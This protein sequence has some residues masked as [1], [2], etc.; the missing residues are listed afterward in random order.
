MKL[1]ALAYLPPKAFGCSKVFAEN[2]D[3]FP[4]KYDLLTY[5]ESEDWP[6]A[7]RLKGNPE[8]VKNT[9]F[10]DGRPNPFAINNL[11]FFTGVRIAQSKGYTHFI[12]LESDC[13]V[14]R[15][16]W[17]EVIFEEYFNL[18]K[19][20]LA[21]GTL[22]CY[23]PNNF[24]LL[25]AKRW[26]ELVSKN[27]SRNVPIA[28][29]GWKGAAEK[30]PCCVFPNGA[31]GVYDLAWMGQLFDLNNTMDVAKCHTA[32]DMAF[33]VN[34]WKLFEEDSYEVLGMLQSVFSS[35]GDVLTTEEQRLQWLR[36]GKFVAV[37]Q[38]K[39]QASV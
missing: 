8:Q 38:V 9:T 1:C 6:G 20:T 18:G 32:W 26:A 11:V 29:Y 14:G 36:E 19:P 34:I 12:Y 31:L 7:V 13:R 10:Q 21:A 33:G 23:N 2:L 37:H 30:F 4:T 5:S 15:K 17:D 28:T 24:S 22:A 25:A 3:Q 39:G 27:I 16:D 35:Y